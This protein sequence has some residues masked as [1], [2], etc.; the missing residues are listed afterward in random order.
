MINSN[1]YSNSSKRYMKCKKINHIGLW[2]FWPYQTLNN[3]KIRCSYLVETLLRLNLNHLRNF[4]VFW[5]L[6]YYYILVYNAW[7]LFFLS[8][9][10]CYAAAQKT[11]CFPNEAFK[12]D[13]NTCV[14]NG[15]YT[16]YWLHNCGHTTNYVRW[17]FK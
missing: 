2:N 13:C 7:T 8:H 3:K 5:Q 1:N 17:S 6:N 11:T 15:K 16:K 12:K 10:E 14:C 4:C 9:V